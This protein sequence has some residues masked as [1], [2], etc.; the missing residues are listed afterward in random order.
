M[1]LRVCVGSVN[2]HTSEAIDAP[3]IRSE[4]ERLICAR[5]RQ[6]MV[7]ELSA[8]ASVKARVTSVG[9]EIVGERSSVRERSRCRRRAQALTMSPT[10]PSVSPAQCDSCGHVVG[11]VVG[12]VGRVVGRDRSA[13]G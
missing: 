2:V 7:G 13:A 6:R 10:A 9:E 11:H 3:R 1:R 5:W 12:R 4:P 8:S